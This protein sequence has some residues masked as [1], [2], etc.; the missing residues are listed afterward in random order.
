M[1]KKLFTTKRVLAR[2]LFVA[3]L[4]LL[5]IASSGQTRTVSGNVVDS[6]SGEP[7]S[8]ASIHLIGKNRGANTS[9]RGTF[10][11]TANAD[12]SLVIS[13][14]GYRELHVKAGFDGALHILLAPSGARL[15]DVVVVGYGTQ[16]RSDITGSVV[17]VPKERL[18][19]LPN[20][21]ALQ[22]LQEIGRA[23]V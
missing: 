2:C 23:H 18:T 22:A 4:F 8:G 7:L 14:V 21:N 6:A 15:A 12:D 13:H 20:T 3:L 11:I 10:S 19:E 5:T 17:S 16:K 1:R 9:S